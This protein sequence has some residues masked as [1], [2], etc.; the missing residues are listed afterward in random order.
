MIYKNNDPAQ[1]YYV[2]SSITGGIVFHE[3]SQ[4]IKD[5]EREATEEDFAN[6]SDAILIHSG[7]KE[8]PPAVVADTR[9]P[10]VKVQATGTVSNPASD[11]K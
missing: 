4:K 5:H 9:P 3:P 2:V 7:R 10:L 1:G 11:A 8:A 6:A